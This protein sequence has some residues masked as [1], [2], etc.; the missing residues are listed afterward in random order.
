MKAPNKRS[1]TSTRPRNAKRISERPM[2]KVVRTAL[3][4]TVRL[5]PLRVSARRPARQ[6]RHSVQRPRKSTNPGFLFRPSKLPLAFKM[7]SEL[8]QPIRHTHVQ[9]PHRLP[10]SPRRRSK[11][12]P[13]IVAFSPS[14]GTQ[15]QFPQLPL[16][17][18]SI[19]IQMLPPTLVEEQ[20]YGTVTKALI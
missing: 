11:S 14:A 16:L 3:A 12:L 2:T 1:G 7:A 9:T 19:L 20:A 8:P 17:S 13:G 4:G 18:T 6:H 10:R 15:N 5:V